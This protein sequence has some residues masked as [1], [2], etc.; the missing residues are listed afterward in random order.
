M[1]HLAFKT[2]THGSCFQQHVVIQFCAPTL[3]LALGV[4][5]FK[6][7]VSVHIYDTCGVCFHAE[8]TVFL[9]GFSINGDYHARCTDR[10]VLLDM[11]VC[12][13]QT[14]F[15]YLYFRIRLLL[16]AQ[17]LPLF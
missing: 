3:K 8:I 17:L 16:F 7:N 10:A 14:V 12:I 2:D 6:Y 9:D 1:Y 13:Q 15:D 11:L 5:F 4:L